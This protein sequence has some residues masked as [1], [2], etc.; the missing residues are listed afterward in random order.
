MYYTSNLE[1]DI[2]EDIVQV[3][4][5]N[6][7]NK[8]IRTV[9]FFFFYLL[10]LF[11]ILE[12]FPHNEDQVTEKVLYPTLNQSELLAESLKDLQLKHQCGLQKGR[13][14]NAALA[15]KQMKIAHGL[16]CQ[17]MSMNE[18]LTAVE[19]WN[20]KLM[21]YTPQESVLT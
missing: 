2:S 14:H 10:S 20:Q 12:I 19:I 6:I 9:E 3:P 15:S 7:K 16:N 11:R 21:L 4:L 13:Q 17:D 5:R 1:T 8:P 18:T